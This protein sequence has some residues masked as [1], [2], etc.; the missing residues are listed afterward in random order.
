MKKNHKEPTSV[1]LSVQLYQLLVRVYPSTFRLQYRDM[2][3]QAFRDSCLR[4]NYQMRLAGVLLLWGRTLVDTLL[5]VIE[6]YS[7]RGTEM[8]KSSWLILSGWSMAVS[9]VLFLLSWLVTLRPGYN[10]FNGLSYSMN[11]LL[12]DSVNVFIALGMLLIVFGILGLRSRFGIG[13]GSLGRAGLN[14]SLTGAAS[15]VIGIIGSSI[16]DTSPWW[17]IF[18]IG[19]TVIFLGLIF[20]GIACQQRKLFS[21]WN[22]LP[23]LTGLLWLVLILFELF[24]SF[25]NT[26]MVIPG[27]IV[28]VMMVAAFA[29]MGLIGLLLQ[30]EV[31]TPKASTV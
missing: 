22:G 2:M 5:S 27:T 24:L 29:G 10:E 23:L 16:S 4:A 28:A 19:T 3:V 15:A 6:Q 1:S 18:L 25:L 31:G 9:S 30:S 14:I 26:A 13:A 11:D 12:D 7:N 20:F 17:Q 21:R 8:K